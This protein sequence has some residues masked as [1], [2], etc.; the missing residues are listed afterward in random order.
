MTSENRDYCARIAQELED[1]TSKDCY[2][3]PECGEVI[4]FDNSQYN[5]DS[6]EY[7][8]Q[9]CGKTFPEDELEAYTVYD[10]LVEALGIEYTVSSR[11]DYVAARIYVT[12]GGRPTVWIDTRDNAVHLS[13]GTDTAWYPLDTDTADAVDAAA[14]EAYDMARG[15]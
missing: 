3:C 8:C 1:C 13:W 9:G 10:Y 5:Q 14:E 12:L 4:T 11:L 15:C 6:G 7:T 2:K